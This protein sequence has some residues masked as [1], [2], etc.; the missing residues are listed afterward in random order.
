MTKQVRL[1]SSGQSGR[2]GIVIA[3]VLVVAVVVVAVAGGAAWYYWSSRAGGDFLTKAAKMAPETSQIFLAVDA[4]KIGL[5]DGTQAEVLAA[6]KQSK[7]FED[8]RKEVKEKLGLELEDDILKAVEPQLSLF[9]APEAG[10][11]SFLDGVD[12]AGAKPSFRMCLLLK[13]KD[14]A[15]AGQTLAAIETKTGVAYTTK[16]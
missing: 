8:L 4:R 14:E 7:G 10:K 11:K 2:A 16:E 5:S 3:V 15:K 6:L 1:V 9:V 12:K 13:V